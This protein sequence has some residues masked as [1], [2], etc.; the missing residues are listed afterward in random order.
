MGPA[1]AGRLQKPVLIIA[2]TDGVPGGEDRYTIVKVITEANRELSRTRYGPDALSYQ[3]AQVGNDAKARA[4]LE[5]IDKH[6][7]IGGL[8]DVSRNSERCPLPT[9]AEWRLWL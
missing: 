2:I 1:R 9:Q 3:L 7:E 5:E 6:P 8:V 4:F